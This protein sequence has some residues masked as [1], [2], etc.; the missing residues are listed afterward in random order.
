MKLFLR[1]IVPLG[2]M[3]LAQCATP[4]AP[5]DSAYHGNQRVAYRL[6]YHHGFMDG[7]HRLEEN[8]ERYH[9]AYQPDGREAFA[10][11]YEA[12]HAAGRSGATTDPAD[13]DRAYRDGYDAGQADAVNSMRPDFQRH[14]EKFGAGSGAAFREGYETGWRE[15][16]NQ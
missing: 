15:G 7:S 11:G 12:G 1:L 2:I 3:L 9:D 4:P 16:R 6:G 8:F 14:R 13:Q 10:R 5:G